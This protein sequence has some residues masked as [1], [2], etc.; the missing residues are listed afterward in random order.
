VSD[1]PRD[2]IFEQVCAERA[3]E[4]E[5]QIATCHMRRACPRPRCDA[6]IGVRCWDLTTKVHERH[7]KHP[8]RERYQHEVPLR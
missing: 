7:T 8:H 1:E 4:L 5:Q 6:P 2:T 3:A